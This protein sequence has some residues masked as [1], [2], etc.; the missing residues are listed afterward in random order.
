M[1][2]MRIPEHGAEEF[3]HAPKLAPVARTWLARSFRQRTDGLECAL[4]KQEVQTLGHQNAGRNNTKRGE[5]G[6]C[7]LQ[8][9]IYFQ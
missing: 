7:V 4:Q 8:T 3:C 6:Q 1:V 5:K 2:P 9:A